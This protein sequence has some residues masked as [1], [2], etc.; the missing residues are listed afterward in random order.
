MQ[1]DFT[2]RQRKI[3]DLILRLSWGCGKK[4]AIIPRQRDFECIGIA[5]THAG[6]EIRWLTESKIIFVEG[7][8]YSFNKDYD[9]W[10]VSRVKPFMPEKLTELININLRH[11][12]QNS[13]ILDNKLVRTVSKT[14]P[15][16]KAIT[17]Q[18]SKFPTH[19]LA[20]PKE[21][22]KK[23]SICIDD[24]KDKHAQELWNKTLDKLKSQVN[25]NNY[26]TW[27]NNTVGLSY[28]DNEFI[29]GVPNSS[30]ADYLN[31]DQRSLIEKTL[32][33]F[34][35]PD[36]KVS[37]KIKGVISDDSPVFVLR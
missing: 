22:N 19:D 18:K 23:I 10:Q 21:N 7:C 9:E 28:G 6:E 13:K 26:R 2:K 24:K 33:E 15:K 27:F 3:L 25:K 37:F 8:N 1:R 32:I 12:Y 11:T 36:I 31:K 5:E 35:R 34:T 17:Y 16:E 30:V 29:V 4:T 14:L 20:L